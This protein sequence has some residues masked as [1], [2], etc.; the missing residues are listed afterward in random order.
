MDEPIADPAGATAAPLQPPGAAPRSTGPRPL[1]PVFTGNAREYFRIWI[2]NL[3]FSLVT[4]GVYSAWAKVRKKKY[5]YGSTTLDGDSF[6]YLG[7]P[8]A[9]LKGRIIA[10]AAVI[11]YGFASQLYPLSR[12]AFL[13]VA[14]FGFPWLIARA[15]T[16]NARNSAWRGLRFDFTASAAATTRFYLPRLILVGLTAGLAYP[17]FVARRHAFTLSS[18]AYGASRLHC[19]I[20]ARKFYGIYLRALGIVIGSGFL[21]GGAAVLVLVGV[22]K[23]GIGLEGLNSPLAT[24]AIGAVVLYGG[25]GVAYA[26]IQA[27]TNNLMWTMTT[28]PGV[29][30]ESTLG[31]W[32]MVRLYLGNIL[33]AAVSAGLLI[34]WGVVRALRYRLEHFAVIVEDEQVHEAS[35]AVSRIDATGQELGDFFNVDFGI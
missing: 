4:L 16:F 9:I 7:S 21:L 12:F 28:G 13:A 29:R 5:F 20:P 35:P 31:A 15:L 24:F 19:E 6:D 17:W 25:Y 8:R 1:R 32:G 33:A 30:F 2:V 14:F 11:V 3:F 23:T 10:A 34:P 26:Y 18:H 22:G 27:R